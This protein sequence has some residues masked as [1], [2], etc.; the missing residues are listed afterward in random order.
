MMPEDIDRSTSRL[1]KEAYEKGREF[2]KQ[3]DIREFLQDLKENDLERTRLYKKWED[4]PSGG[5]DK[6]EAI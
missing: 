4:R 3:E 2:Q 1:Q 6:V 5:T